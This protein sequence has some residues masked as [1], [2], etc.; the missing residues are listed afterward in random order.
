MH[1]ATG[2]PLRFTAIWF[3]LSVGLF[4]GGRSILQSFVVNFFGDVQIYTTRDEN[5]TFYKARVAM[6][7][8]V[9]G[10][11]IQV[12]SKV[13]CDGMPYDR[14]FLFGHSLGSSIAMDAIIQFYQECQQGA[15][16]WDD[17][18]RLCGFVTF[19]TALEKTK[20]FFDV[21]NPSP[22]AS[23][24]Q[25]RNDAYGALFTPELNDLDQSR[26]SLDTGI[27]W[28]NYWYFLDP[29]CNEIESYRSYLLPG[30]EPRNAQAIRAQIQDASKSLGKGQAYIP[31]L[32]CLDQSR[33]HFFSFPEVIPHGDYLHDEH[34]WKTDAKELGAL[35]IVAREWKPS[36]AVGAVRQ[37]EFIAFDPASGLREGAD[38]SLTKK[39]TTGASKS[40]VSRRTVTVSLG[41][42]RQ[43]LDR[44]GGQKR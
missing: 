31:R 2:E 43:Y 34:F 24:E 12:C 40:D 26:K 42:A 6:L 3:V 23:Y 18:L 44:N 33:W 20:Y 35:D 30:D 39:A 5:N 16:D 28:A 10:V 17:F 36:S 25:W 21:E 41:K 11:L 1:G 15:R 38:A 29:V 13:A 19:G 37:E 27:F 9:S 4:L 22:S 32:V 14:V 8:L 7:A